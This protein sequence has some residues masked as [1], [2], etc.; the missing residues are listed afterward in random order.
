MKKLKKLNKILDNKIIRLIIIP[1][2]L[3][4]C[5]LFL[6]LIFNNRISFSVLEYTHTNSIKS[7]LESGKLL[8]GKEINGEFVA[9]ENHMGIISIKFKDFVK[10]DFRGEDVLQF[11]IKEKG[12]KNWYYLNNYRS[13]LLEDQLVY[14][15]GFPTIAHSKDK[16]YIFELESILGNESNA[17]ELSDSTVYTAHQIPKEFI[18]GG[19]MNLVNFLVA[20]FVTSFTNINFLLSSTVFFLPLFFYL[21]WQ[22]LLSR[23]ALAKN[24]FSTIV[25]IV[26]SANIFLIKEYYLGVYIGLLASWILS[27]RLYRLHSSVSLAA[28]FILFMF[29]LVL[30]ILG[31]RDFDNKLNIWAY[32][33]LAIG[34]VQLLVEEK[35]SKQKRVGYKE[36]IRGIVKLK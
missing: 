9:K 7:N 8:K 35:Y 34:I 30:N 27:I 2:A 10:P 25:I 21:I 32:T 18:L 1:L 23:L 22:L 19:K 4:F 29:W 20:K 24:V 13:G 5:G 36:F 6:A 28:F 12:D 26:I 11:R 15:F 3:F 31:V 17:V 16:T 33:F 14:P